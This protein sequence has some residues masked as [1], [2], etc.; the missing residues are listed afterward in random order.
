MLDL[1]RSVR[2]IVTDLFRSR[3][4]LLAENAMLRQQLDDSSSPH[5]FGDVLE[6]PKCKGPLR[7]RAVSTER[8]SARL[9]LERLGRRPMRPR[10]Q[11]LA[12]LPTR[13]CRNS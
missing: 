6:C 3:S 4:E 13:T 9:I 5:L 2:G 8:H 11:A 7:L 12:I 1:V 10:S